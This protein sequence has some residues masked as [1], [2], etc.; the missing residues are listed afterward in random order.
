M[1]SNPD[2][3][4]TWKGRVLMQV[5]A[6]KADKPLIKINDL[7][8]DQIAT[9]N[10]FLQPKEYEVI[11]E[12]QQGISLPETKKYSVKIMIADFEMQTTDKPKFAENNYN[13]WSHR[14]EKM[15]FTAPY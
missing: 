8:E 9:V 14:F 12:I 5:I 7:V 4:S 6:D 11:A 2:M 13:R 10:S 15:T 1:N 3:A